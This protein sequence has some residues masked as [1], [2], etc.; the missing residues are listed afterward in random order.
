MFVRVS[1]LGWPGLATTCRPGVS[2][3]GAD[4]RQHAACSTADV[5]P[6]EWRELITRQSVICQISINLYFTYRQI[7][8]H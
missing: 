3:P 5:W 8:V 2:D 1:G 6:G 4:C 7:A